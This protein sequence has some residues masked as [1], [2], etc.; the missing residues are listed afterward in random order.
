MKAQV[1]AQVGTKSGPSGP[2]SRLAPAGGAI[3]RALWP[4]GSPVKRREEKNVSSYQ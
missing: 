4:P 3:N 1:E 2:K